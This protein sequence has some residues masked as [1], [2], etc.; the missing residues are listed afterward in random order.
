MWK[1]W[2]HERWRTRDLLLEY[3]TAIMPP[4]PRAGG[5]SIIY[6]WEDFNLGKM[7]YELAKNSGYDGTYTDFI[8]SFGTFISGKSIIYALF[9]EFPEEGNSEL[10]YFATDEKIL[11]Y[12]DNGYYP[13]N[14]MLIA[15]TTLE[16]GGA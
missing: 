13:I 12:W 4:H 2:N 7:L 15:N 8:N 16:G 14:A 11:Y 9:N 3:D 1:N 5:L 6:P 10:L